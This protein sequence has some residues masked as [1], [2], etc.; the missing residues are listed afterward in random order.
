MKKFE[1]YK[2]RLIAESPRNFERL[3]ELV[4]LLQTIPTENFSLSRW[5]SSDYSGGDK[6][7]GELIECGTVACAIGWACLHKPFQQLGLSLKVNDDHE[8][9]LP[10][11]R[12][13]KSRF[14]SEL[15]GQ[16]AI[17]NF[18]NLKPQECDYLF[19]ADAYRQDNVEP[20]IA[21]VV[22]RIQNFVRSHN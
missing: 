2:T 15:W 19:Y 7:V 20:S 18:F 10:C 1:F 6:A 22:S 16:I 12:N 14:A 4:S 9:L 5:V 3:S 11:Y 21:N 13:P 8:S 17:C